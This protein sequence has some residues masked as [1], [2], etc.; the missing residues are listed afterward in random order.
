[1]TQSALCHDWNELCSPRLERII[2]FAHGLF[3]SS[4]I[5]VK[6]RSA[7][8]ISQGD[9]VFFGSELVLDRRSPAITVIYAGAVAM[10]VQV[11]YAHLGWCLWPFLHSNS[12]D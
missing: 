3:W 6:D 8:V 1:M 9:A 10:I 7:L 12:V 5:N 4:L 2:C 11:L